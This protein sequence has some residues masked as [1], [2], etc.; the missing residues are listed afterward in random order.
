MTTADNLLIIPTA[1]DDFKIAVVEEDGRISITLRDSIPT[2]SE[3]V[4][5]RRFFLDLLFGD[6]KEV[7]K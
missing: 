3:A 1:D 6:A 2:L 5:S 4:V 7:V